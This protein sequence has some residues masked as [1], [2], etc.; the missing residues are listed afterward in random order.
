MKYRPKSSK[1][2]YQHDMIHGLRKYL[3]EELEPLEY[4]KA[5]FPA[6]I[7]HTKST[8]SGFKVRF[9]YKTKTG[10]KLIAYAPGTVQE[11]FVVTSNAEA[12]KEKLSNKTK[13]K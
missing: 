2:K 13:S 5:I 9:K 11:V 3:E 6:E 1:I 4:V 7:K 8:S 10:A 12:L